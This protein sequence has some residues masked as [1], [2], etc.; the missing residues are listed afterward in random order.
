MRRALALADKGSGKVHPNPMVGAVLVRGGRVV[1][2]GFHRR[3]GE[4]HAE[5]EAIRRA[6]AR[7]KGATLY[8]TLEPCSHWGKTP[9]CAPAILDAGIRRVVSAMK[10]PNP[11]VSGKGF[12]LLQK[13]R[14][15]V[16]QGVLEKEAADLN[17]AFVIW[18][19]EKRPY[20]TLKAAASL[21]GRMATVTGESQWITGPKARQAG[22]DLRAE[23]D[24]I[25]VGLGTVKAD[26]PSLTTHGRGPNPLRVIFDS[27]L[28][29]P[30]RSRIFNRDSPTWCLA[31]DHTVLR[32]MDQ[33]K[34]R[35]VQVVLCRAG[36]D[37]G[38][39]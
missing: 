3:F 19:K 2:E 34:R 16:T 27:R 15:S 39:L 6:G 28:R 11:L 31:T 22:H 13:S 35:G 8:V 20:V 10:D 7:A 33:L 17:R 38:F 24:A 18:I 32:H 4:A 26:N 30:I 23:A 21:D 37:G 5:V 9:P 29:A 25:A 36:A 14:V 1:G 12:R